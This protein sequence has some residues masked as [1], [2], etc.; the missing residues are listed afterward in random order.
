MLIHTAFGFDLENMEK[1]LF[2]NKVQPNMGELHQLKQ[3]FDSQ[4]NT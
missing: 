1:Q 2:F 3:Q 4:M